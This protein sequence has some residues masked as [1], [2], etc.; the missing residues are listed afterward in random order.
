M[1]LDEPHYWKLSFILTS[2]A[3]YTIV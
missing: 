2:I 1:K 3:T